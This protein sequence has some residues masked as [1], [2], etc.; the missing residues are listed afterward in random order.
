[1]AGGFRLRASLTL[2]QTKQVDCVRVVSM[3]DVQVGLLP[4]VNRFREFK[5]VVNGALQE[6]EDVLRREEIVTRVLSVPLGYGNSTG[7]FAGL[8]NHLGRVAGSLEGSLEGFTLLP[9]K[10]RQYTGAPSEV[11]TEQPLVV[12]IETP[13][14]L[15]LTKAVLFH[16]LGHAR[17]DYP[18]IWELLETTSDRRF[19]TQVDAEQI[20]VGWNPFSNASNADPFREDVAQQFARRCLP[21]DAEELDVLQLASLR[22]RAEEGAHRNNFFLRLFLRIRGELSG[23]TF[24]GIEGDS[25]SAAIAGSI[26]S[27]DFHEY[28]K[29]TISEFLRNTASPLAPLGDRAEQILDEIDKALSAY[30]L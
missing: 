26:R 11:D 17:R 29:K 27:N 6:V 7:D 2:S 1:M 15:R 25:V 24:P 13:T 9:R 21:Q 28:V 18:T 14:S 20:F 30:D 8:L 16:E 22:N 19:I 12:V 5:E 4:H 23:T 3:L 10:L